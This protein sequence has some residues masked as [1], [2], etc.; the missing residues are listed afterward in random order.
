MDAG[1]AALSRVEAGDGPARPQAVLPWYST[2]RRL[3][4]CEYKD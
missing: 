4:V 3:Q 1:T 2:K